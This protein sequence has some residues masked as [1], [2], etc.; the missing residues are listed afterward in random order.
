[1]NVDEKYQIASNYS[2]NTNYNT[3][4]YFYINEKWIS[5]RL[6][7]GRMISYDDVPYVIYGY[8]QLYFLYNDI[9]TNSLIYV[10]RTHDNMNSFPEIVFKDYELEAFRIHD[11]MRI[12]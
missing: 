2:N 10:K 5:K 3:F 11:V 12:I 7:K 6:A 1:M 9:K 4:I 8:N